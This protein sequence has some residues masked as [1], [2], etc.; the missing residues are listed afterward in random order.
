MNDRFRRAYK[1]S[2]RLLQLAE[3]VERE[4]KSNPCLAMDA[5][6]LRELSKR[7]FQLVNQ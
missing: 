3:V 6:R 5:A 1:L 4:A 7:P 2:K